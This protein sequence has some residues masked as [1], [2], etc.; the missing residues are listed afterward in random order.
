MTWNFGFDNYGAHK[1]DHLDRMIRMDVRYVEEM[2]WLST[3][4]NP[5]LLYIYGWNEPYE[6]SMLMPTDNWGDT[7][8][9][10]AKKFINRFKYAD[11]EILPRTLIIVDDLSLVWTTDK[12]SWHL[13][14][15]FELMVYAM[16]RFAPQS[17]VRRTDEIT[18]QM[19]LSS[20]THT[21]LICPLRK[22]PL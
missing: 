17:D 18:S 12:D 10:L 6:S 11:G 2:G 4:T 3:A 5:S 15:V 21:A 13:H 19:V 20:Y 9:K 22:S 16:R 7:K 1:R 14:I 8:A